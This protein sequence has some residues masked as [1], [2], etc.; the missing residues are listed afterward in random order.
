MPA[1]GSIGK[2]YNRHTFV[3]RDL[4]KKY[5]KTTGNEISWEEFSKIIAVSMEEAKNCILK[6]PVGF[7]F[8]N[9]IGHLA[10]NMFK[11][12]GE[13]KTYTNIKSTTG[14]PILNHNLHTGGYCYRLQMFLL[15]R[16]YKDR[17]LYWFFDAERKFDRSLAKL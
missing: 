4:W 5:M 8:P 13:F 1:K 16:A 3:S 10:V 6:E 11:T 9:K 7:Q 14:K 12:Y 17:K 2:F 15:T